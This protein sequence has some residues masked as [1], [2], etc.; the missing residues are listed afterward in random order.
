MP[1]VLR[2][3]FAFFC[4]T[5]FRSAITLL[6][7]HRLWWQLLLETCSVLRQLS[8]N[9]FFS[10]GQTFYLDGCQFFAASQMSENAHVKS[11][12]LRFKCSLQHTFHRKHLLQT[13]SGYHRIFLCMKQIS[14]ASSSA[15]AANGVRSITPS[16][17][18]V[19]KFSTARIPSSRSRKISYQTRFLA[20]SRIKVFG[21]VD[22]QE[23]QF[24]PHPLLSES[25]L[26]SLVVVMVCFCCNNLKILV[27]YFFY[28]L[29]I[30][31][32]WIYIRA[33]AV[34]ATFDASLFSP[35]FSGCQPLVGIWKAYAEC[36]CRT[37]RILLPEPDGVSK[38]MLSAYASLATA[39]QGVDVTV[40][41]SAC[42]PSLSVCY[43][44]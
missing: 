34:T 36:V 44:H 20:W 23:Y 33:V 28:K 21:I 24:H 40:P 6:Y 12:I 31:T 11:H 9:S 35:I 43:K 27:L 30:D 13:D 37:V 26:R 8:C 14:V 29:F 41:S 18:D 5:F 4:F 25:V 17:S 42:V 39:T 7:M 38:N 32:G 2:S 16:A 15:S 19:S 10:A 3:L 22:W 1:A